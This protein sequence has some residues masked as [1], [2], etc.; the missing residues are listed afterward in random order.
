MYKRKFTGWDGVVYTA[1]VS[2]AGAFRITNPDGHTAKIGN[3][4]CE[5][6]DKGVP[7]EDRADAI[8][9]CH[10]Q[11]ETLKD[12]EA[13]EGSVRLQQRQGRTKQMGS[14]EVIRA[15][16]MR[17]AADRKANRHQIGNQNRPATH[18]RTLNKRVK[19]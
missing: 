14:H 2:T 16:N 19:R 9:R 3:Q 6:D 8:V 7:R 11:I 4:I 12:R 15:V 17:D 1:A 18:S 5:G 13:F 10:T